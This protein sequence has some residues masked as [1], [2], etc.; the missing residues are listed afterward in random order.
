[1]HSSANSHNYAHMYKHI[2]VNFFILYLDFTIRY[3]TTKMLQILLSIY[4]L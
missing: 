4:F 3:A 2:Q 1:M